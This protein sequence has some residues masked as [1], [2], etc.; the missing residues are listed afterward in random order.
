MNVVDR[1]AFVDAAGETLFAVCSEPENPGR[2][3]VILLPA[4]GYTFTP[5]RN[6]WGVDL[7]HRLASLGHTTVRFDWKGIG[8]STG[9]V[10]TFALDRPA[11]EDAEAALT[12]LG[13]ERRVLMGQCY[14]A[15]TALA[16]AGTVDRLAGVVLISPPVR[17]HARGEGTATMKAYELSA[18]GYLKEGAKRLR[19]GMLT[20]R[21]ELVRVARIGRAFLRARWQ[22]AT[23]RFRTPDPTPWVSSPFLRQMEA[24]I[25][26][27]TPTLLLY[28]SDEN[29]FHEFTEARAGRLGGLLERGAATVALEVI[30]G[31]VHA[32]DRVEVQQAVIDRIEAW[33]GA[34]DG[35]APQG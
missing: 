4:G 21:T 32:L 19:P 7:A 24:L 25:T 8:D 33:V 27:A 22:K 17:D 16:M 6:R 26:A 31:S 18:G 35:P 28:G 2:V 3:G 15:R 20:D 30:P 29:D 10:D 14:G 34:L 23:A 1:P 5:Q 11:V 12:L 9:S 13:S